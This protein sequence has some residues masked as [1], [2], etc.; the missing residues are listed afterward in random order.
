MQKTTK[1]S[2]PKTTTYTEC[3]LP[4]QKEKDAQEYE[5]VC[6]Y[7]DLLDLV[8]DQDKYLNAKSPH[9]NRISLRTK[10]RAKIRTY[11]D[12]V[13]KKP[14]EWAEITNQSSEH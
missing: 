4:Y 5:D 2:S 9:T 7:A 13:P 10:I 6:L 14:S 3:K 1:S 8:Q 11:K 12:P